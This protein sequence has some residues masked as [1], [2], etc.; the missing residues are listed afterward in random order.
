[1]QHFLLPHS[2][3][4]DLLLL[5]LLPQSILRLDLLQ[6]LV[7]LLRLLHGVHGLRPAAVLR[8]AL[9]VEVLDG[10]ASEEL[11]L[12]HL[13]LDLP[14]PLLFVLGELMLLGLR[15]HLRQILLRLLL[16]HLALQHPAVVLLFHLQKS[17]LTD[18][19]QLFELALEADLCLT[20]R[21]HVAH[22][23]LA[24]EGLDAVRLVVEQFVRPLDRRLAL[25]ELDLGFLRINLLPLQLL[26][27]KLLP[28]LI[29][30]LAPAPLEGVVPGLGSRE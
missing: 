21:E 11:A 6:V 24:V 20:L 27:L 12:E 7:R 13:V 3:L 16:L 14:V 8:V 28:L 1:M 18:L 29:S 22:H 26:Q 15:C 17:V 10:L 4:L 23:H 25:V 30:L 9:A 2:V 5:P 19:L